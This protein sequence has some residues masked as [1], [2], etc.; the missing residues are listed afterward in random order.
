M[1]SLKVP[2]NSTSPCLAFLFAKIL[3]EFGRHLKI[4]LNTKPQH[5]E[6]NSIFAVDLSLIQSNNVFVN[7]CLN[8][9]RKLQGPVQLGSQGWGPW[10]P[11]FSANQ[12]KLFGRKFFCFS[13]SVLTCP[14]ASFVPLTIR[15]RKFAHVEFI[16][17]HYSN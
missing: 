8:K 7:C 6:V 5:A 10:P 16:L 2:F 11:Y 13:K 12:R 1:P 15:N 17:G 4:E 3:L 9:R 14:V